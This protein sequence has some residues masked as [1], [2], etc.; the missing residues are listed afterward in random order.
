M[1]LPVALEAL[2]RRDVAVLDGRERVLARAHG[3]TVDRHRTRTADPLAAAELRPRQFEI[4]AQNPE[5]G[6][7]IVGVQLDGFAVEAEVDLAVHDGG[8]P[9]PDADEFRTQNAEPELRNG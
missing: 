9:T 6:A 5:E 1:E 8:N 4:V 7:L 3:D 2:D